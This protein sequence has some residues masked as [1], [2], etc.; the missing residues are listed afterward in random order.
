MGESHAACGD[1]HQHGKY[2][3][4]GVEVLLFFRLRIRLNPIDHDSS[5]KRNTNRNG[6]RQQVAVRQADFQADPHLSAL[7]QQSPDQ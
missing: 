2:S 5:E 7:K 4:Y 3:F 6:H 1:N